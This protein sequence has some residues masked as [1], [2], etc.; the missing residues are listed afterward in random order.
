GMALGGIDTGCLDLETSGLL[1]YLTLFNTHVPRRGPLNLPLLGLSQGGKTWVLCDPTQVKTGSGDYQPAGPSAKYRA[2]KG[3][4]WANSIEKFQEQPTP[5]KL[6]G[7]A[8]VSQIHYWGHYPVVDLEFE[9]DTPVSVG[10]RA[11]SSFLPGQVVDSMLPGIVFEVH[12]HN[13]SLQ[14]QEG[15]LA[16]SFP[17]PTDQEA[18]SVTFERMS[19]TAGPFNGVT[20]TG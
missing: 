7:V 8:L 19:V 16:L 13:T 10:L 2:W 11:W 6:E 3:K 20:I 18:G 15:T 17:G 9:T 14:A 1:G 4:K 5:L 12:L